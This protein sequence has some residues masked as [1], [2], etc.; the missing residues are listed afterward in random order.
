[1]NTHR[2]SSLLI[3]LG[4]SLL[5]MPSLR[6]QTNYQVSIDTAAGLWR[7]AMLANGD[8][9]TVM[10]SP[11]ENVFWISEPQGVPQHGHRSINSTTL[12]APCIAARADGGFYE[13]GMT[14]WEYAD[15]DPFLYDSMNVTY[16]VRGYNADGTMDMNRSFTLLQ[17]SIDGWPSAA[18]NITTDD[19][20]IYVAIHLMNQT[21]W[22]WMLKM[23]LTG[24][25]LWCREMLMGT[26]HLASEDGHYLLAPTGSGGVFFARQ[27]YEGSGSD[28]LVGRLSAQGILEWCKNI[29]YDISFSTIGLRGMTV[30]QDGRP[31]LVGELA[32]ISINYGYVLVVQTDGD[33]VQGHFHEIPDDG[34]RGWKCV[35][36][37][38]NGGALL[39]TMGSTD[40]SMGTGIAR[41][42]AQMEVDATLWSEPVVDGDMLHS[43][44]PSGL[45]DVNGDP[46]LFGS[47]RSANQVFGNVGY[48][49]L[50]WSFDM[51]DPQGCTLLDTVI[52]HI[53]I[54]DAM[55]VM[56][57]EAPDLDLAVATVSVPQALENLVAPLPAVTG[58]CASIVGIADHRSPQARMD[59]HPSLVGPGDAVNVNCVHASH[60]KVYSCSGAEVRAVRATNGSAILQ[61]GT[62]TSGLYAIVAFDE[63]GRSITAGKLAVR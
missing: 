51:D 25:I 56:T 37:L 60:F 58:T 12:N 29:V 14:N 46:V 40:L 22:T 20:G 2:V 24:E 48:R 45:G 9:L 13:L 61:D 53:P 11:E 63:R 41:V 44:Y 54:P 6:A 43:L 19:Q 8:L 38:A 30:L 16:H 59:V 36:A 26:Q 33:A 1:M 32:G 4:L 17:V 28:I 15:L 35:R 10:R 34:H 62:L 55:M 31:M 42:D 49:P 50:I 57:D 3:P 7:G 5:W 23:D 47:M 39:C 52:S 21:P 18:W 27:N